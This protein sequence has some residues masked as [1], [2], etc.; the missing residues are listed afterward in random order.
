MTTDIKPD[1]S[2]YPNDLPSRFRALALIAEGLSQGKTVQV[3]NESYSGQ[4]FWADNPS[5]GWIKG[6]DYRL[7]PEPR[8]VWL[9][10]RNSGN[11]DAV[12]YTPQDA[13]QLVDLWDSSFPKHA[14]HTAIRFVESPE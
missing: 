10:F 1:T 11:Q 5:P 4:S 14:P 13:K 12:M 9:I 7:K 6:M 2:L 3:K 8:V